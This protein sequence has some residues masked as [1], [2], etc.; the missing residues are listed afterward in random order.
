VGSFADAPQSPEP[1]LPKADTIYDLIKRNQVQPL[2]AMLDAFLS[3]CNQAMLNPDILTIQKQL[4]DVIE[5]IESLETKLRVLEDEVSYATVSLTL[6]EVT[7]YTPED[8][9]SFGEEAGQA[10]VESWQS[11][12]DFWADFAIGVVAALP[13]LLVLGTLATAIVL[14]LLRMRKKRN[15]KKA[16]DEEA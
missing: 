7:V 10:F 2:T 9:K 13:A 3:S 5:E 14:I 4:Y 8:E 16:P 1:R 6:R 12:A 11:F 15:M